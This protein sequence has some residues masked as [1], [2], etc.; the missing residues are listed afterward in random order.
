MGRHGSMVRMSWTR[1]VIAKGKVSAQEITRRLDSWANTL[2][3]IGTWRDKTTHMRPGV[4]A[5]LSPMELRNLYAT[6]DIATRIVRAVVDEAF[7][8]EW[9]ILRTDQ[10]E[11][12]DPGVRDDAVDAP[13]SPADDGADTLKARMKTLEGWRK[14]K[15]A[16]IWG[17]LYGKGALLLCT[18]DEPMDQW[19]LPLDEDRVTALTA[20]TV[21]DRL[22][23]TPFEWYADLDGEKFGQIA[24]YYVQPLGV[25]MGTPYEGNTTNPPILV[26]E[27]RLVIFGG[28]LTDKRQRLAN[29]GCDYS[30][31]Q[32]CFRALQLTNNNWQSASTLLADAGQGVFKIRGLIDMIAQ[33]PEVM[34][35][36]M[37]LVDMMRSTIRAIILDA[38]DERS[39]TPPEEFTRV[40]TPFTGIPEMLRETWSRLA[41]AAEM[42][43]W[44]LMGSAPGSLQGSEEEGQEDWCNQVEGQQRNI[45]LPAVD[46]VLGL[47]ARAEGVEGEW[48]AKPG[49]LRRMSPAQAAKAKADNSVGFKNMVEAGIWMPE[50]IALSLDED[51]T[52]QRIKIDTGARRRLLKASI[53]AAQGEREQ[54]VKEAKAPVVPPGGT[55]KPAA[56]KPA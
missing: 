5:V 40:A 10:P 54:V 15:E 7:R 30:V 14:I 3:G 38:G 16:W 28:E 32:K 41:C 34:Q 1:D 36:R 52:G 8:E 22:D 12:E 25:Y 45:A 39:K 37:Q 53:A 26:H 9:T 13:A 49:A 33:N 21:L 4:V 47:M 43:L 20:I 56:K 18:D 42:P 51:P 11:G 27:T 24:T 6:D 48:T 17:R 46:R 2:S 55:G 35:Q 19:H 44:K 50:E 23:L 31:L 29:Q